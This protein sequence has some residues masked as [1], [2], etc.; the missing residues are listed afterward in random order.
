M[1]H[2][3][4]QPT[5][6]VVGRAR[7]LPLNYHVMWQKEASLVGCMNRVCGNGMRVFVCNTQGTVEY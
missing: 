7:H 6:Y 4:T 1:T 3:S 2:P 5:K